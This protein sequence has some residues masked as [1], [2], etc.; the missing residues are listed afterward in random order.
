MM[1][2]SP[3]WL[4]QKRR[5]DEALKIL[6][7]LHA[8]PGDPDNHAAQEEYQNIK[9]Q[10]ELDV[11]IPQGFLAAMKIASYRKRFLIGLF[12]QSVSPEIGTVNFRI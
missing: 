7:A 10:L 9:N 5:E 1:P 2:E 8:S 6:C 3:R 12:V 4:L 11:G